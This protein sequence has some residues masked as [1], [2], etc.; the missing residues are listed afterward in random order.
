MKIIRVKSCLECP[1]HSYNYWNGM[2]KSFCNFYDISIPRLI[3]SRIV[4]K[5][6]PRWCPL[7]DDK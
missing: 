3:P 7:E 2:K 4:E 5:K 1:Y 6:I